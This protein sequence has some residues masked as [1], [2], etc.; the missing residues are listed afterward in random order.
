M[1]LSDAL[2]TLIADVSDPALNI[3]ATPAVVIALARVAKYADADWKWRDGD[4]LDAALRDLA[5]A[6]GSET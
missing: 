4:K 6:L 1:T 3:S 5:A 2:D